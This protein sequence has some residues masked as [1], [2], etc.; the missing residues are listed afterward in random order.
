MTSRT[1]F[2]TG[3]PENAMKDVVTCSPKMMENNVLYEQSPGEQDIPNT[4]GAPAKSQEHQQS[5]KTSVVCRQ[6]AD[7]PML[8]KHASDP[9]SV[10]SGWMAPSQIGDCVAPDGQCIR[11]KGSK[12][13][14]RRTAPC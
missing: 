4:T 1:P 2:G 14:R 5:G 10:F 3:S 12:V 13:H 6:D 7:D 8:E 9:N 11:G